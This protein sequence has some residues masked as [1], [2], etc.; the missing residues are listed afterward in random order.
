MNSSVEPEI[1]SAWS[2]IPETLDKL[3]R[4]LHLYAEKLMI[5]SQEIEVQ[6]S[7]QA[8]SEHMLQAAQSR[9][10]QFHEEIRKLRQSFERQQQ[11]LIDL[12]DTKKS[13]KRL[14]TVRMLQR[15]MYNEIQ[16]H[17]HHRI[18]FSGIQSTARIN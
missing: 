2:D 5:K 12:E 15:L 14:Q 1:D 10:E 3:E 6:K 17:C 4:C 11:D 8:T 13:L 16:D 9:I 18:C 7:M